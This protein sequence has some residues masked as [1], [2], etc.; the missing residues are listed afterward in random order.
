MFSMELLPMLLCPCV[1]LSPLHLFNDF[2]DFF[3]HV[4]CKQ[5]VS[6]SFKRQIPGCPVDVRR[7]GSSYKWGVPGKEGPHNP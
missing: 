6:K 2:G 1:S 4:R 5:P 7:A 3:E